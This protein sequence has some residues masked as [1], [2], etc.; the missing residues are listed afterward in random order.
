MPNNNQPKPQPITGKAA[1]LA[2]GVVVTDKGVDTSRSRRMFE[3][4]AC[5]T[6]GTIHEI[7]ADERVTDGCA[8]TVRD[9]SQSGLGLACR[10]MYNVGTQII[11]LLRFKVGQSRPYFGIIRQCRYD[12][13]GLYAIGVEFTP[14]VQSESITRWMIDNQIGA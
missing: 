2:F 9:L 7:L 13:K 3:R 12:G 4:T 8:C 11:V 14:S 10:R 1:K 5:V 6:S